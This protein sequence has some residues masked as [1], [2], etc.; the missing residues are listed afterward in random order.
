MMSCDIVIIGKGPAGISAALYTLRSGL[1]TLLVAHTAGELE[2][3]EI[4][5]NYYGHISISGQEL[6]ETGVE[7]VQNLGGEILEQEVT[8]LEQTAGGYMVYTTQKQIAAKAVVIATG[9]KRS[10][11]ALDGLEVFEGRGVSYC[12]VCDGFFYRGK[13]V[14]VLGNGPYAAKAAEHLQGIAAKVTLFTNAM[15]LLTPVEW[16]TDERKISC[17]KG[18]NRLEAL[19]MEDGDEVA[20]DGLF[21]AAGSASASDFAVRLG[22]F[23][24]NGA[25]IVDKNQMTNLEGV[26][27]AGDC[28][29]GITQVATAV[30]EGAVAG[31]NAVSYVKKKN[32]P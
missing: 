5:E 13:R 32:K 1:K 24:E 25:L 21:L 7:Q 4:I 28:T 8:S 26:F 2:R 31:M 12:A 18:E 27:A 22:V 30:G 29:G 20:L 3:A 17:L 23:T 19:L 9:K 6:L 11:V 14:G 10:R 16:E 15:P